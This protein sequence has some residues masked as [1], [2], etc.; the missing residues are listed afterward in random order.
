VSAAFPNSREA[1]ERF[2]AARRPEKSVLDPSRP[3]GFFVEDEAIAP[4]I[5]V[6]VATILLTNR[7]C[8]YRCTM[9]DLWKN[10]LDAP[11]PRGAVPEQIRW[12]LER[13]PGATHVKLYN[14]GSFFDRAAV[15]P[16]DHEA[17]AEL[18][19]AFDRVVVECHPDLVGDNVLRFRDLLGGPELEVAIGL[20]TAHEGA[21]E[22]LNKGM[23]VEDFEACTRRLVSRGIRVRS[24]V[25]VGVPF[26]RTEEWRAATR[27]SIDVSFRAGAEIV[28]LIPTRMGNG[29]LEELQR[30]G[31]FTPPAL[32]DLE[33][34]LGDSLEGE[35]GRGEARGV[36]LAD[37][38]NADALP[39][40]ACCAAARVDRLRTMNLIQRNLPLPP[41]PSGLL[42]S[43]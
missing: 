19:R 14:S 6:P 37:L 3:Y 35:E 42:H 17:I 11:T 28:S 32:G 25:L 26:L 23:T 38:W 27:A 12:A 4:G 5:P 34:A 33:R 13:M 16:A 41:C 18:L 24:F 8:A 36:V 9:C 39:A 31:D 30:T 10:T 15:P 1:R 22:K 20:E 7:E 2:I 40:P 29:T 43:S 21:L